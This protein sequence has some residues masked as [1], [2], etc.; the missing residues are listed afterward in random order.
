MPLR[1]KIS[2]EI[3]GLR[4]KSILHRHHIIPRADDRS[5]NSDSNLAVLCPNCH[6]CV[7]SGDIIIIG[8]YKTTNGP[9]LIW[10]K[11]GEEPPFSKE[12][13]MVKENPLVITINEEL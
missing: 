2:C 3:C 1:P 9:Q 13:W 11:R 8:L 10:F 12:F 6:S 4:K 5:T 7:H